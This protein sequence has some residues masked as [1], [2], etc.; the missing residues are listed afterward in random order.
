MAVTF[1]VIGSFVTIFLLGTIWA[2]SRRADQ[3]HH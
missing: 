2:T 3:P 1:L